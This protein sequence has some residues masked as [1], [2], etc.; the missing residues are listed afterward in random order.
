MTQNEWLIL[1]IY[2]VAGLAIGFLLKKLA[3]P[4]LLKYAQKTSIESDDMVI[5]ILQ[6]WV[7]VW[8]FS[9]GLFLGLKEVTVE[10]QYEKWLQ[11]AL[12]IFFVLSATIIVAK[13]IAGMIRIKARGSDTVIPSSSIIGNIVKVVIYCIGILV[14]LQMFGIS[15]TPVLTA[16]GVGGLAVALALQDTLSNL[17][18]GIQI[19]ASGK[20]NPGDFV[21]LDSGQE[22]FVQD[23]TWRN[24]TIQT[25]ANNIVIIPNAKLSNIIVSNYYLTDKEIGFGVEIRIS[26]NSDLEF[27]EKI[28]KEVI[29]T[30]LNEVEG[31]VK[32]L[33]PIVR[34]FAF[35]D[36][37]IQLRAILR[38]TEYSYQFVV[39]HEF[40]KRLHQRYQQEGIAIAYPVSNIHVKENK[41]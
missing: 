40:I 8:F 28:T 19:I 23:V 13:V 5:A 2:I 15:I 32:G 11:N 6:K 29:T 26:Y 3:M 4:Y 18:A 16:L 1:G 31:G 38:V 30:T 37:C 20:I 41:N 22:G 12:T 35:S 17:F 27:V 39:R 25:L 7:I 33:E 24:T 34:Y 21:L 9:L 36:S 10:P 14:I